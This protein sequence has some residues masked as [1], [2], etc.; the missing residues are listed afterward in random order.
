MKKNK[1]LIIHLAPTGFN[2]FKWNFHEYNLLSK[3][4]KVEIHNLEK[5]YF[6]TVYHKNNNNFNYRAKKFNN[7]YQWKTYF[8]KLIEISK[9]KKLKLVIFKSENLSFLDIKICYFFKKKKINFNIQ[10]ISGLPSYNQY[11]IKYNFEYV[12]KKIFTL[13]FQFRYFLKVL[14]TYISR[15]ITTILKLNPKVLLS[16]SKKNLKYL[17][18]NLTK[19]I[20]FHSYNY[21]NNLNKPFNKILNTIKK[22]YIVF[23]DIPDMGK[24]AYTDSNILNK[25]LEWI[26][27]QED[28]Y[29]KLNKFF[30]YL[31]KTLNLE[32]VIAL[33]PKSTN[34]KFKK[35]KFKRKLFYGITDDLLSKC[36][37]AINVGSTSI[38]NATINYIPIIFIYS[39]LSK[40]DFA[41]HKY[42][43]FLA[44]ILGSN[45]INID[46]FKNLKLKE[47]FRVNRAKYDNFNKKY[48]FYEKNK[49]LQN[50][51]IIK[52]NI[53]DLTFEMNE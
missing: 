50:Y 21:S 43:L 26:I 27:N 28:W 4:F 9:K 40:K 25:K 2:K 33:H 3:N 38:F 48:V 29:L 51:Q 13:I 53:N 18:F 12:V 1:Y 44:K 32:V 15:N 35:K 11:E 31:E 10:H 5:I 39:N 17:N 41:R 52:K 49:T 16:T 19:F 34:H 37:L 30:N 7:F 24:K 14:E 42:H 20:G 6:P 45:F 8:L 46:A 36:E 23:I 22:K 47:I